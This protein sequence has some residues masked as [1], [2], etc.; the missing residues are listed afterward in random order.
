MVSYIGHLI[1]PLPYN[2]ET[3]ETHK[4]VRKGKKR[5]DVTA[6]IANN[7]VT[8]AKEVYPTIPT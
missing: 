3:K 8:V 7:A 6:E 1:V 2:F 4:R 5:T